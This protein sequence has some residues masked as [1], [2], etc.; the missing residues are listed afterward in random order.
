MNIDTAIKFKGSLK[1][2]ELVVGSWITLA[3]PAIAEIMAN[4]GFRWLTI[5]LEHSS[6]TIREAE[7]LIRV[8]SQAGVAALVRLTANNPEQIK[9]VLDAGAHGIIVPMV[10]SREDAEKAIAAAYYPPK[11]RR[12]VGLARAQNYGAGFLEH[13]K[14]LDTTGCT[15]IVQIEHI[16]AVEH[17]EEILSLPDIDGYIIGPYDLSASIGLAGELLHP[18]VLKAIKRVKEIGSRLNKPGGMHLVEPNIDQLRQTISD[19]F[20]FIAYSLD[21]RMLDVSSRLAVGC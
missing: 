12:G 9:R 8:I 1:A 18:E 16:N 2:G 15:V 6:I 19:G 5:D 11:G 3:H 7:E 17:A 13:K 4:A 14:W 20:T 10:N 21:I